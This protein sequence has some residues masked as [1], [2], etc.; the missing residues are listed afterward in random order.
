VRAVLAPAGGSPLLALVPSARLRVDRLDGIVRA[1]TPDRVAYS[2]ETLCDPEAETRSTTISV[3]TPA[4]DGVVA[5]APT[6][7]Q[8]FAGDAHDF[9]GVTRIGGTG[10]G[11]GGWS[12][13]SYPLRTRPGSRGSCPSATAMRRT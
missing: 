4:D 10:D 12:S 5:A 1:A 6:Q 3:W 13:G 8:D 7:C 9:V 2:D 11:A